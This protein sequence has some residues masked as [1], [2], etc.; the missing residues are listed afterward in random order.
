M[1]VDVGS[2]LELLLHASNLLSTALQLIQ[3]N[4]ISAESL[5]VFNALGCH[6]ALEHGNELQ[7]GG[8]CY[9]VGSA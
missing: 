4:S 5:G 3:T 2:D 7:V 6:Q 8:W 1:K 9:I